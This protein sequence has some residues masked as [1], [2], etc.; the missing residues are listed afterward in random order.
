MNKN[1]ES[2]FWIGWASIIAGCLLFGCF[3][4]LYF[5][6]FGAIIGGVV[7]IFLIG[8]LANHSQKALVPLL[9]LIFLVGTIWIISFALGMGA[10]SPSSKP[11][12][13]RFLDFKNGIGELK[14]GQPVQLFENLGFGLSYDNQAEGLKLYTNNIFEAA[15][16]SN[17]LKNIELSFVDN[18]LAKIRAVEIGEGHTLQFLEALFGKGVEGSTSYY[19][20]WGWEGKKVR[21]ELTFM[22][23]DRT[24]HVEL[25]SL[26]LMKVAGEKEDQARKNGRKQEA[27]REN[28][29]RE[30]LS[31][32]K[33]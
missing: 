24:S 3:G 7:N 29:K 17:I 26:P 1:Q 5:G 28:E 18:K 25:Q 8:V 30:N 31:K 23:S 10:Y 20:N 11:G 16:G 4:G 14:L 15:F 2:L 19:N 21:L 33:F 32:Q 13:T 12:S 22:Q 27:D 9:G 6:F